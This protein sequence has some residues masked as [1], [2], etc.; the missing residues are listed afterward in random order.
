MKIKYVSVKNFGAKQ[1]AVVAKELKSIQKRYSVITPKIVVE[2]AASPKSPLHSFFEW[3]DTV[4]AIKFREV[5]AGHMIRSVYIV[6]AESEDAVPV[7]AFVNLKPEEGDDDF[8][9]DQGYVATR[10]IAGRQD[11]QNQVL[12][13][14]KQQ[15]VTWRKKFGGYKEFFGVV[16][17]ID[18]LK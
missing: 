11:Y 15:I 10:S 5:Q 7:R 16:Q 3:D 8:I 6:D 4:A 12:E 9:T 2:Q 13:Y 17:Q 14:A 18:A 1:A